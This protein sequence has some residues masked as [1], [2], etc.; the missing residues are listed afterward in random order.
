MY[1]QDWAIN[2]Q[3]LA[4]DPKPLYN[5]PLDNLETIRDTIFKV[6]TDQ[7]RYNRNKKLIHRDPFQM[8]LF[9]MHPMFRKWYP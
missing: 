6:R 8:E 3:N 5:T 7:S 4:L 1:S 2:A 9:E